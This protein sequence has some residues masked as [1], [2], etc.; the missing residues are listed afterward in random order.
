MSFHKPIMR[1]LAACLLAI[2]VLPPL[3]AR[4]Q[5]GDAGERAEQA[6]AAYY[7]GDFATALELAAPL[8][9]TG[10]A[11]AQN[12]LGVMYGHGQGVERD[13]EQARALLMAAAEGGVVRANYNLGWLL[14]ARD[15]FN[16]PDAA[17]VWLDKAIDAGFTPALHLRALM[18]DEGRGG[19][20]DEEAAAAL[21]KRAS[22]AGLVPSMVRM[23][24]R[25]VYAK[26]VDEDMAEGLRLTRAAA[27]KGSAEAVS[28]LGLLYNYGYGVNVDLHAA[29]ALYEFAARRGYGRGAM[30]LAMTL[31][32][33]ETG[34]ADPVAA[35]GWC[36]RAL[37]LGT[38]SDLA[39]FRPECDALEAGLGAGDLEKARAFAEGLR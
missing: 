30:N 24:E 9:A 15:G 26:G 2:L 10:N 39:E 20:V 36:Y 5:E 28:F 19:P 3:A 16:D 1:C 29:L 37:D 8:A 17:V 27:A 25:Y 13:L 12:V 33:D 7:A 35:M 21:F 32:Y 11:V 23:A 4:A 18:H 6:R 31:A 14:N 38:P 22:D 34:F